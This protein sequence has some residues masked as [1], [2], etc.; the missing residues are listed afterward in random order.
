MRS[1]AV[2][3]ALIA[4]LA[5]CGASRVAEACGGCFTPP[6][7]IQQGQSVSQVTG[8]RMI[9]SISLQQTTLYDQIQ[10]SGNPA[11]FAWVLPIHGTVSI[12]LSSDALFAA[13]DQATQVNVY[14]P[15]ITCPQCNTANF[16]AVGVSATGTGSGA[17][18][19]SGGVTVLAQETVGPY[20]TV[21]LAATDPSALYKWLSGHG[22]AVPA[23]VKPVVDKYIAEKANF[24]A[25]KLVPGAG[26]QSMR[27]VRIT[28]PGAGNVL[29]MRMVAAGTGATT[30]VT[31][32]VVGDGRYQPKNAPSFVIEGSDLIWDWDTQS[33]NYVSYRSQ[34]YAK[35]GGL[36]Y[37]VEYAAS[38]PTTSGAGGGG[39][40]TWY[41]IGEQIINA[42]KYTPQSSGYDGAAQ[43]EDDIKALFGGMD[44]GNAWVTR[45]RGELSRKAF[46]SD[47][48]LE[49]ASGQSEVSS[50]LLV[51]KTIGT[52]PSCP[53]CPGGGTDGFSATSRRS[54]ACTVDATND[55][56]SGALAALALIGLTIGARRWMTKKG[57]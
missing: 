12:G 6:P 56:D 25:M 37:Q 50:S 15:Q 16:G 26:V 40:G 3:G 35:S 29:P 42:A 53:V 39:G 10:Y 28:S 55:D 1:I 46:A 18:G 52:A 47:L 5:V 21:Q 48:V 54:F 45:L 41:W 13:L 20:E 31:L 22:Y 4:G 7:S 51:S 44:S 30:T 43:A 11:E 24:L 27:P 17:G 33:S 38:N 34:L 8:H 23:D 19:A 14:S 2:M 49:A 57:T 9:L 32:W 36:G